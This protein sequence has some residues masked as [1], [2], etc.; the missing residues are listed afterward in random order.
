MTK[1]QLQEVARM[2][3]GEIREAFQSEDWDRT[4]ALYKKFMKLRAS[5]ALRLEM[6][7][8]AARALAAAGNR[9][10]AREVLKELGDSEYTKSLHYEFLARA[11]LDLKEYA[12]AARVSGRA[13]AL[14]AAEQQAAATKSSRK[15]PGAAGARKEEAPAQRQLAG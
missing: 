6:G 13:E 5:A 7:C 3:A 9:R 12:N 15:S 11:Y 1:E 8:L 4:V 10:T 14:R 2:S